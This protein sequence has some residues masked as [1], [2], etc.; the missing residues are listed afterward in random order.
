MNNLT[1]LFLPTLIILLACLTACAP[2]TITLSPE[3]PSVEINVPSQT[4]RLATATE[5][6]TA[7]ATATAIS[8]ETPTPTATATPTESVSPEFWEALKA[9]QGGE[10]SKYIYWDERYHKSKEWVFSYAVD[11]TAVHDVPI[12]G[13]EGVVADLAVR[14][15]YY[16]AQGNKQT[17]LVAIVIKLPDGTLARTD[18]L[19]HP[20]SRAEIDQSVKDE[21]GGYQ[22]GDSGGLAG[23]RIMRAEDFLDW[24]VSDLPG[25]P[26]Y[27]PGYQAYVEFVKANQT[28]LDEFLKTG[29]PALKI[30]L[31]MGLYNLNGDNI[32][33][34]NFSI[35]SPTPTP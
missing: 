24:C 2:T 34:E 27:P 16:D 11:G 31:P 35:R 4:P 28:T 33:H 32:F 30:I 7:I 5:T 3:T 1:R 12:P 17:I 25:A 9:K 18:S 26:G 15:Y 14:S 6:P 23:A 8:I 10:W 13:L 22:I 21:P 29:S 19:N 20:Y